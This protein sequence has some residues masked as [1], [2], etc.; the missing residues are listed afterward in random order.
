MDSLITERLSPCFYGF[1]VLIWHAMLQKYLRTSG[2][3]PSEA[4]RFDVFDWI[5]IQ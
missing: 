2:A 4:S 1:E 3:K 5:S